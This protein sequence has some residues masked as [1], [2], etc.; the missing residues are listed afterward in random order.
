M[1]V[2]VENL[3]GCLAGET[4]VLGENLLQCHYVHHIAHLTWSGIEP[5]LLSFSQ[6]LSLRSEYFSHHTNPNNLNLSLRYRERSLLLDTQE[7]SQNG[8]V[9]IANVQ[10]QIINLFMNGELGGIWKNVPWFHRGTFLEFASR[11][12]DIHKRPQSGQPV[13]HPRF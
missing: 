9:I 6:S 1:M 8:S 5:S 7:V 3:A 2:I 4:K 13:S 10:G 11:P 12:S